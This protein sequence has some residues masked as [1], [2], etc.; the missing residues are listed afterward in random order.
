MK[1]R[2]YIVIILG[3]F[4]VL[5]LL[6]FVFIKYAVSR[7]NGDVPDNRNQTQ[8]SEAEQKLPSDQTFATSSAS[9]VSTSPTI[10]IGSTTLKVEIADTSE[11][12][13]QG[14][15]GRDQLPEDT[16]LLFVFETPGMWGFWMKDMKFS[17]D[18]IWLDAEFKAVGLKENVSPGTYPEQTFTPNKPALYVL[19]TNAGFAKSQGIK[20]GTQ[21]MYNKNN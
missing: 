9:Q 4:L 14:L 20:L 7:L 2:K 8:S 6:W 13:I 5:I 18:M 17:I 16:G 11:E 19:E 12:R 15:S 10:T 3:I 21:L 1:T